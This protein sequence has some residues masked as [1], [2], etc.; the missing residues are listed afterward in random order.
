MRTLIIAATKA[1]WQFIF[2]TGFDFWKMVSKLG[3]IALMYPAPLTVSSERSLLLKLLHSG[4]NPR[5]IK[6]LASWLEDRRSSVIVSGAH[7]AETALT[8][9]VFQGTVLGPPLWN[10]FYKDAVTVLK[11]L[12]FLEVVFA[13]DFNCW[14][15]FAAGTCMQEI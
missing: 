1:P 14:K 4:L 12:K 11:T 3:C 8:D 9:S 7:S 13:D 15:P 5:V 6:F 2:V 10:I